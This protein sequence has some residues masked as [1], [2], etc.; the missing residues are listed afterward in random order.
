MELSRLSHKR[1]AFHLSLFWIPQPGKSQLPYG[2]ETQAALWRGPRDEVLRC[3]SQSPTVWVS[4]LEAPVILSM[5]V[6]P[7]N[8]LAIIL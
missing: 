6:A 8:I 1:D 7:E 5:T 4:Y 3:P 2:E